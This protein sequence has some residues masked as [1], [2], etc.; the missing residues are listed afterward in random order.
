MRQ[1]APVPAA[2]S[3][4]WAERVPRRTTIDALSGR[5]TDEDI[6]AIHAAGFDD[7]AIAEVVAHVALNFFTNY[8]NHVAQTE[9]DFP[10]G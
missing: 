1:S 7:G 2:V 9:I 10:K 8:F 6:E 4:A 5:V 3:R